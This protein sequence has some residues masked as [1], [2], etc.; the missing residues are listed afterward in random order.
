MKKKTPINQ[1]KPLT[2]RAARR[3]I[4]RIDPDGI[5]S[6]VVRDVRDLPDGFYSE[7]VHAFVWGLDLQI[8][9]R[10]KFDE[11]RQQIELDLSR[12]RKQLHDASEPN[13]PR[14]KA[15][16]RAL[17]TMLKKA[18]AADMSVL[19]AQDAAILN[20]LKD[21]PRKRRGPAGLRGVESRVA[22][23]VRSPQVP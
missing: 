9:G 5:R 14:T 2:A 1:R 19:F 21:R 18:D 6:R 22:R 4:I 16:I 20:L 8:K 11:V 23:R 17:E 15:L 7:E 10:R 12:R 13:N 3:P